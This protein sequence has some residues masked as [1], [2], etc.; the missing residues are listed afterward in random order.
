MDLRK[1][2]VGLDDGESTLQADE[3]RSEGVSPLV[4]ILDV[5]SSASSVH[6]DVISSASVESGFSSGLDV[7]AVN[8]GAFTLSGFDPVQVQACKDNVGVV[9]NHDHLGITVDSG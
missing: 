8:P 1:I 9:P 5:S 6:V 3:E 2:A 7:S 4:H